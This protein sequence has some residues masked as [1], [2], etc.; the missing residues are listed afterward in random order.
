MAFPWLN[1]DL[2]VADL[3]DFPGEQVAKLF[4]NLGVNP[5]GPAIGDDAFAVQRAKIRSCC[6]IP[7][8]QVDPK[9]KRLD[10]SPA[11][12]KLQRVITKEPEVPGAAPWSDP[13]RHR[14]YSAL[15]RCLRQFI[16][17]G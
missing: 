5:P 11:H 16:E 15:R 7:R 6:D 1:N 4:T 12:F 10:N 17:V 8:L 14:N 3:P 13:W 2:R 9:A